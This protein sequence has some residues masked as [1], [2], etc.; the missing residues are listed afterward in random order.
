MSTTN[1]KIGAVV[2]MHCE[3]VEPPKIKWHF[4]A[5][6]DPQ[7]ICFLLN[8]NI[9]PY[10]QQREELKNDNIRIQKSEHGFLKND[11]YLDCV[12][13]FILNASECRYHIE[14]GSAEVVG[15]L[16]HA[17]LEAVRQTV[18]ASIHIASRFQATVINAISEELT[19]RTTNTNAVPS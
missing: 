17:T 18:Q 6:I 1:F 15:V 16:N 9:T 8:S 10:A 2:R 12:E 5:S 3:L 19:I 13:P 4:I 7:C 11:S 14:R